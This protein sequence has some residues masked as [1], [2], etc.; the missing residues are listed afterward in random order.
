MENV[1]VSRKEFT[2]TPNGIARIHHQFGTQEVT[3]KPCQ[4][5]GDLFLTMR[6]GERMIAL[7]L[8]DAEFDDLVERVGE[9]RNRARRG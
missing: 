7:S 9:I 4:K 2:S 1:T 3:V 5:G 8:L 6:S